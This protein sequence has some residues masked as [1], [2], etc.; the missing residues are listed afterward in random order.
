M[1]A[2]EHHQ[3]AVFAHALLQR[4]GTPVNAGQFKIDGFFAEITDWRF[5]C[6]HF[7]TCLF[8]MEKRSDYSP[9]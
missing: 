7:F 2:N 8:C 6:Y 5:Q 4:P 3:Q 9:R 1:I